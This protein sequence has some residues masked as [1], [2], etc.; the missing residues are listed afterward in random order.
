M[1]VWHQ[2]KVHGTDAEQWRIGVGTWDEVKNGGS[3]E[4][5]AVKYAWPDKRGH[6]VRGG[7]VPMGAVPQGIEFAIATGSLD[8]AQVLEAVARGHRRLVQGGVAVD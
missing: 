7:E 5:L 2:E 4:Q 1:D 3:G 6:V 8:V